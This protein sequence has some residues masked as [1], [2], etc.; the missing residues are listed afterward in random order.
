MDLALVRTISGL[1]TRRAGEVKGY[2]SLPIRGDSIGADIGYE[3][4]G[5]ECVWWNVVSSEAIQACISSATRRAIALVT[6]CVAVSL[7]TSNESVPSGS[8]AKVSKSSPV[9]HPTSIWGSVFAKSW[10]TL[11]FNVG[12][13]GPANGSAF[14]CNE[15]R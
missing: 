10:K 5:A 7:R 2:D 1:E 12:A 3:R 15:Q 9:R 11:R 8:S 14:S 6:E 13:S 4:R